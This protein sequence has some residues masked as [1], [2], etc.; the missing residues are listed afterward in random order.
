MQTVERWAS[1]SDAWTPEDDNRLAELVLQ[2]IRTGSTQLKAFEQAAGELGRT[3]AACGYRWNGVVRRN[4]REEIERAKQVRKSVQR[5]A[6]ASVTETEADQP[7]ATAAG[8]PIATTVTSSDTIKDVITFLQAFDEQYQK[9]RRQVETLESER[10]QLHHRVAELESQLSRPAEV[11][12][13]PVTPEQLEED[14]KTLFAIMERARRL[15]DSDGIRT[16]AE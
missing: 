15:L 7:V 12:D 5:S 9:L 11:V 6:T 1:R 14:S 3:A 10:N 4:Y 13:G 2:H 16:R 8:A